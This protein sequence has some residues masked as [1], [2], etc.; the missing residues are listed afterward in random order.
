MLTNLN[1]VLTKAEKE[2]YAVG[3]FNVT[4]L[5]TALGIVAAAEQ[6]SSPVILQVSEKTVDY[7]GLEVVFALINSLANSA[8]VPVVVHLDHGKNSELTEKALKI[9]FSSIM[10]DVSKLPKNQRIPVVKEF[11]KRAHLKGVSI[12]AEEDAIEGIE[13]YISGENY[14]YTDVSRAVK[15]VNET[16]CDAFAV[17]IGNS[18]GKARPDEKLDLEL[19]TKIDQVINVPLVLHGASAT[20]ELEIREAISRGV[21]KIN[22]D[23][24]LR[25]A[26]NK[27]LRIHLEKNEHI[28]DPRDILKPTITAVKEVVVDKMRLFGSSGKA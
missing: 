21:R 22:I 6:E 3:A 19:L 18:H 15:F 9:G 8:R 17:S 20:P 11:V 25:L 26:V 14:T 10:L 2:R 24:D 16:N 5:E 12:E 7:M 27:T 13:D 1:G 4:S 23:T 28:Y